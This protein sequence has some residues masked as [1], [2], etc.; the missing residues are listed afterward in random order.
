MRRDRLA[1][2]LDSRLRW[3]RHWRCW[4]NPEA[5]R[6]APSPATARGRRSRAT[7]HQ[8][9]QA[10]F[11]SQFAASGPSHAGPANAAAGTNNPAA[12][13]D[14]LKR[15]EEHTSELQSLMRSSYAVF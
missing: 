12:T 4:T 9:A 2:L 13:Q 10:A 14:A 15:S 6:S 11:A 1:L 3:T 5:Y 7:S 8:A